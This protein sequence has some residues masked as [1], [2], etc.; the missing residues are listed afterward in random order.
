MG[1]VLVL[2]RLRSASPFPPSPPS[3]S[4]VLPRPTV[5]AGASK[6]LLLHSGHRTRIPHPGCISHTLLVPQG[7]QNGCSCI[8][9][10]GPESHTPAA[11]PGDRTRIAHPCCISRTVLWPQRASQ[12]LL[13][14]TGDRTRIPHPCCIS[15]TLLWPQGPGNGCSCILGSGPESHTLAAFPAL[16]AARAIASEA[17]LYRCMQQCLRNS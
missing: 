14:H 13:L 10:T 3:S 9:V 12:W 16:D 4:F 17:S 1:W 2:N 7:P 8:L 11:F 15:R 5:A 6:W